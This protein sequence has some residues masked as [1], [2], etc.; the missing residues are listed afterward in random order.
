MI[1]R[2]QK[3]HRA[4]RRYKQE[5]TLKILLGTLLAT[6]LL[7]VSCTVDGPPTPTRTAE[8]IKEQILRFAT[9]VSTLEAERDGVVADFQYL[10]K[11]MMDMS[12]SDVFRRADRLATQQ[13]DLNNRLLGIEISEKDIAAVHFM[14]E[15]AYQAELEAYKLFASSIRTGDLTGMEDSMLGLLKADE[16]YRQAYGKL[17]QLLADAGVTTSEVRQPLRTAKPI[18][19]LGPTISPTV[20]AALETLF[21]V[22]ANIAGISS[23]TPYSDARTLLGSALFR[24]LDRK[25]VELERYGIDYKGDWPYCF[26]VTVASAA[27]LALGKSE[28]AVDAAPHVN[29]AIEATT[30]MDDD[31]QLA[32]ETGGTTTFSKQESLQMCTKVIEDVMQAE[33]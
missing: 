10:S 32:R 30:A 7:S 6:L 17:D 29:R 8:T 13:E 21:W 28:N 18:A 15:I 19:T 4:R 31:I 3:D 27:I 25:L 5:F 24:S 2:S 23:D 20:E 26:N 22:A 16:F 9:S 1:N 33:R 14:F 11:N 12:T